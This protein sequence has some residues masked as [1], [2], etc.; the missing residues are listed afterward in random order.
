MRCV[1]SCLRCWRTNSPASSPIMRNLGHML[2][3]M[4]K[5][6]EATI[7]QMN[8]RLKRLARESELCRRLQTI[9]GVGVL[10]SS[11]IVSA[12]ADAS[13]FNRARDLAAWVGLVPQQ[14][15]TGGKPR[16]RGITKRGNCYLR[17]LFVQG[18][19]ALWVWKDK[20]PDAPLQRWL[21]QLAQRRHVHVA[22]CTL[23]NKLVRIAW[24]VL[25]TGAD[26]Q[27]HHCR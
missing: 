14:H 8:E 19:R 26:F 18:A 2:L 16:L 4:W 7:E 6:T 5:R 17:R 21:V 12:I 24:A 1:P 15:T 20:H 3:D 11:A 13:T 10:L 9:A 27:L 25:R 22:V 23:A